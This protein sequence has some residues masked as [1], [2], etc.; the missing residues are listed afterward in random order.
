MS[1]GTVLDVAFLTRI[2]DSFIAH[3]SQVMPEKKK[4]RDMSFDGG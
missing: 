4:M 3:L 2:I 1:I